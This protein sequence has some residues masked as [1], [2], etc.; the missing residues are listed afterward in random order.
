MFLRIFS[1]S[2]VCSVLCII[3]FT[4]FPQQAAAEDMQD[5]TRAI[6]I[7]YPTEGSMVSGVVYFTKVYG[8][9]A[10]VARVEGLTPGKH[11]FHIHEYGDCS[12]PK[13]AS[14]GGHYNPTG[15]R[16]GGPDSEER[17]AGD[18]GNIE[19]NDFGTAYYYRLDGMIKLNGPDS[20][21]GRGVV[22]HAGEDDLTSQPS[23]AAGPR[24][25]CGTIAI[26]A[27]E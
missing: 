23:G 9:V 20:I 2:A 25:A 8:G 12:D 22:V 21:I 26:R 24:V 14:A 7:V 17:H 1:L 15:T 10:V 27:D 19:A 4:L 3:G 18:L 6:A 16:H 5:V 11:G 13:G